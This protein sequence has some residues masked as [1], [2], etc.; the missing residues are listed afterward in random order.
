MAAASAAAVCAAVYRSVLGLG[1]P[2]HSKVLPIERS[3]ASKAAR[4]RGPTRVTQIPLRPARPVRPERCTYVSVSSLPP[5]RL[6]GGLLCTT[7]STIISRPRAATSVAMSTRKRPSRKAFITF[8]RAACGMSP[9]KHFASSFKSSDVERASHSAFVSQKMMIR[10][11]EEEYMEITS[12]IV[13][14]RWPI[15]PGA[16]IARWRTSVDA[17]TLLAPTRSTI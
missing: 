9:C 14:A 11:A 4:S 17:L 6:V 16:P 13:A 1:A 7:S 15:G 2:S 3:I 12:L 8:S 5:K 10:P